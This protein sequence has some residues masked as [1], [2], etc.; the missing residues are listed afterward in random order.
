MEIP[1]LK[2]DGLHPEHAEILQKSLD[3][4]RELLERA[5]RGPLGNPDNQTSGSPWPTDQVTS[6]ISP[7]LKKNKE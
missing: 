3:E 1:E 5:Q 6:W 4:A 2:V 7:N